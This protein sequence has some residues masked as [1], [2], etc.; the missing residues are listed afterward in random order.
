MNIIL[1]AYDVST[2]I[3]GLHRKKLVLVI[4]VLDTTRTCRVKKAVVRVTEL[5][6]AL[7]PIHGLLSFLP[8]VYGFFN[9][10][11]F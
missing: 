3:R 1:F 10:S 2:S 9:P 5:L 6:A 11:F 7:I 4:P 8:D